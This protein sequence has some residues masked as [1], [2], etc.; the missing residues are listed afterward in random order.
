MKDR[1]EILARNL[2]PVF[3]RHP[4]LFAYLFGSQ[5]KETSDALSDVDIAVFFNPKSSERERDN[6]FIE[7]EDVIKARMPGIQKIDFVV[8]NNTDYLTPF[9]EKEIVYDGVVLYCVDKD[10]RA[11]WESLA[12]AEWLDWEPYQKAYDKAILDEIKN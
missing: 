10:A 12:I 7:I 9:L 2:K 8:L 3:E 6:F 1:S 11:H 4:A 5:A